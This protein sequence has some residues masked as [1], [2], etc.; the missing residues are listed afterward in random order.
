VSPKPKRPFAS[1]LPKTAS[2][3][4]RKEP[5]QSRAKATVETIHEAALQVLRD[6]GYE[7]LT[8][9]RVAQRAGVSVGTFYQYY[10]DKDSLARTLVM[11]CVARIERALKAVLEENS[12]LRTLARHFVRRYIAFKLE[13]G[14]RAEALRSVFVSGEGQNIMSDAVASI[15]AALAQRIQASKPH[16]PNTHVEEVANMWTT[17]VFGATSAMLERRP[18]LIA[19]PWFG[20]SLECAVIA[21]LKEPERLEVE[22]QPVAMVTRGGDRRAARA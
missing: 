3:N 19:E 12:N 14:A 6:V 9:T 4:V 5:R 13:G 16:W 10:A 18:E 17:L 22:P 20:E 7:Q 1:R 15:V 11:D 21:L 2:E 8:T